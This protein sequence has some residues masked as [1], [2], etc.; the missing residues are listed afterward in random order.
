MDVEHTDETL[1][2]LETDLQFTGGFSVEIVK[3]FRKRLWFI[4]Q[5]PDERDLYA[6]RSLHFEKLQG[7]RSH[8][9][10]V[11]LNLQWRLILEITETGQT[12]KTVRVIAIEDYH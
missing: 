10:S 1:C 11:R 12:E 8:Q 2:R 4:R 3:S 7:A 5:A 6:M 9:R